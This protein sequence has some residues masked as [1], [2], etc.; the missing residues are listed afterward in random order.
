M[1]STAGRL[2]GCGCDSLL[3]DE[4]SR[5]EGRDV[6]DSVENRESDDVQQ[7]L[8]KTIGRW[9]NR[10]GNLAHRSSKDIIKLNLVFE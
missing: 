2:G 4:R 3:S 6:H 7:G 9:Q 8:E 1:D 10:D 5:Q